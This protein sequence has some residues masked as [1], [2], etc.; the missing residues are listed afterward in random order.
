MNLELTSVSNSG[1]C[2]SGT[3]I[4]M[5]IQSVNQLL[6]QRFQ[7]LHSV[8]GVGRLLNKAFS[9]SDCVTGNVWFSNT[10]GLSVSDR[11]STNHS[12]TSE[13]RASIHVYNGQFCP[14]RKRITGD[15][16]YVTFKVPG[17]RIQ[18]SRKLSQ[19]LS[20]RSQEALSTRRLRIWWSSSRRTPFFSHSTFKHEDILQTWYPPALKTFRYGIDQTRSP[21]NMKTNVQTKNLQHE[22]SST[23]LHTL[24]ALV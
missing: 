1:V 17:S 15:R 14:T 20:T 24:S 21:S 8:F 9:T 11:P 6:N 19:H 10:V 22:E 16:P 5:W 7:F 4:P 23:N 3:A 18:K 2:I 12:V 13:V